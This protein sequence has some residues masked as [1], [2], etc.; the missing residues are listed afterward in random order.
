MQNV[1]VSEND[2][3]ADLLTVVL[4][5]VPVLISLLTDLGD[6]IRDLE[7]HGT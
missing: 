2:I 3:N 1:L 6:D 5:L 7:L 4:L